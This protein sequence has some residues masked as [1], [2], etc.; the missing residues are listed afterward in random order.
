MK[1]RKFIVG[2]GAAAAWPLAARAQTPRPVLDKLNTEITAV[3]AM[4][5]VKEQILTYGFLPLP[6]RG[7]DEL[8]DFVKSEIVRWG[9]VVHEAGIA[10]SQ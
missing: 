6:N 3:L 5:D 4:P 7:L 8:K 2:L 10:A 9:K 1:R